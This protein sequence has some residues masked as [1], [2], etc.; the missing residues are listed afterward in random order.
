MGTKQTDEYRGDGVRI[1]PT[2]GLTRKQVAS[3]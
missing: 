3:G 1:A 2:S